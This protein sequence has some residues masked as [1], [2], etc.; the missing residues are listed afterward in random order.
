MG[1]LICT[2]LFIYQILYILFRAIG[3]K[4][5]ISN[6]VDDIFIINVTHGPTD[7]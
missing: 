1:L 4:L 6:L 3:A 5:V 7:F 2:I